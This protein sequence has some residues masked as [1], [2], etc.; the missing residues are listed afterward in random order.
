[1]S[2]DDSVW[3]AKLLIGEGDFGEGEQIGVAIQPQEKDGCWFSIFFTKI[4]S[5][6][7][8]KCRRKWWKRVKEWK[9]KGEEECWEEDA[10]KEIQ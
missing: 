6:L 1:M 10:R 5:M 4:V 3:S 9:G 2:G 8:K 7:N